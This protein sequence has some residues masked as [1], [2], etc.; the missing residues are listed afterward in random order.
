MVKLRLPI[1]K[2]D[3]A[4]RL[5]AH[6]HGL[7]TSEE[8]KGSPAADIFEALGL[9]KS[10]EKVAMRDLRQVLRELNKHQASLDRPKFQM[11]EER[12]D[13]GLHLRFIGKFLSDEEYQEV[14][15]K[16]WIHEKA[17]IA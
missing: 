1:P 2:S 5:Y 13:D 8:T 15:T 9:D 16:A 14:K 12:R 7:D 10:P 3:M 4:C 11:V 17:M 6:L